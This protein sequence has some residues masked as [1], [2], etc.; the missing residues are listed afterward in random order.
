MS[1]TRERSKSVCEHVPET[2]DQHHSWRTAEHTTDSLVARRSSW[3]CVERGLSTVTSDLRVGATS[4]S[5]YAERSDL[6]PNGPIRPCPMFAR[7]QA[8][9][10]GRQ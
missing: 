6:G 3:V 4:P 8:R 7:H 10:G 1:Q 9:T 2:R 5:Q